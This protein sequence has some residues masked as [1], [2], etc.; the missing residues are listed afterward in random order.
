[1]K[2]TTGGEPVVLELCFFDKFIATFG[3]GNIDLSLALGYTGLL[4]A[5]GTVKISV[6]L[7]PESLQ[8]QQIPAVFP[9]ALIGIA[10]KTA[11]HC[12]K[13]EPIGNQGQHQADGEIA[14]EQ[15]HQTQHHAGDQD[16]HIQ[17]VRAV[18]TCHE[19]AAECGEFSHVLAPL[20]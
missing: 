16:G 15:I 19:P 4:A 7:V 17:F 9:V 8:P 5:T 10:G 20:G 3:A 14:D 2:K 12:P 1:M 13:H 11:E 6:F 18:A